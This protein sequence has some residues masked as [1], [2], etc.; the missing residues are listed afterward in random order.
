[1]K[2][3]NIDGIIIDISRKRVKNINLYVYPP[4]ARVRISAPLGLSNDYLM[5]FIEC[6]LKWIK[7]KLSVYYEKMPA[8]HK[9]Y[10]DNETHHFKGRPYTLKVLESKDSS[11]VRISSGHIISLYVRPGTGI[12]KKHQIMK[13]WYRQELKRDIAVLI[14]KW[15]RKTGIMI[16]DW[17]VR[18]M[19]TKWGSINLKKRTVNLNL[20]LA[21]K[22]IE[23]LEYVIV[24]ELVHLLEKNHNQ[25]F[26]GYMDKFL[27]DW[28][29]LKHDLN[30]PQL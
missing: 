14:N 6:R 21:K 17:K 30:Q 4:E 15:E 13:N 18:Q 7:E 2:Q 5:N 23:C 3:V 11:I 20:E 29:R 16:K 1:M 26:R 27:P 8:V 28:K 19:K 9:E 22:P 12:E 24:H 10:R 25:V